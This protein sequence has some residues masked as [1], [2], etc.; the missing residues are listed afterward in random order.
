MEKPWPENYAADMT[1]DHDRKNLAAIERARLDGVINDEAA[2]Y[3]RIIYTD[4]MDWFREVF[5]VL[6]QSFGAP[7]APVMEYD[8]ETDSGIDEPLKIV[9]INPTSAYLVQHRL[10]ADPMRNQFFTSGAGHRINLYV[11]SIVTVIV[12]A[13]KK[14]PRA[15]EKI[16]GKYYSKY[17]DDVVDVTA[18]VLNAHGR[19]ASV[20]AISEKIRDKFAEKFRTNASETVL[21]I[22]GSG[23]EKIAV[24]LVRELDKV[25]KPHMRLQDVWRVKCLFDL[26]PQARTFIER[27]CDARPD[28]VMMISDKF[29]DMNNPRNYRDAKVIVDIGKNG[30]VVPMEI[31]CQVRT[32][33]DY[34]RKT[35]GQY[36]IARRSGGRDVANL[37]QKMADFMSGGIREYNMMIYRCLDVIF[38]RVGWNIIYHR[39]IGMSLLEGFPKLARVYHPAKV[40][41]AI[42]DKLDN[43]IEN[44]VFHVVD[45]PA[46]LTQAQESEIFRWLVGF[47]LVS[48]MPYTGN[49]WDIPTD[50]MPGRLFNFVMKELSRYYRTGA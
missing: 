30:H 28:R 27:I 22:I 20:A 33:F 7:K 45:A 21:A 49:A 41:D 18:R 48:A 16:T 31:M 23:H 26:I 36:E 50:T 37:E 38:D 1:A 42:V 29:F 39:G 4:S 25:I 40:V 35:H 47:I 17:V 43:A 19:T 15:L 9:D 5:Y 44:E 46:K 24:D 11:S 12:G 34:E 13:Q 10:D 14:F 32:F 6:G 3:L 2:E 8:Y